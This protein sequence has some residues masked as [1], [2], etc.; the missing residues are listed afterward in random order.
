M[1]RDG[2]VGAFNPKTAAWRLLGGL[3]PIITNS[4]ATGEEGMY[5][6]L[7]EWKGEVVLVIRYTDVGEP[8]QM[9]KLDRTMMVWSKIEK[10]EDAAVFW[11]RKQAIARL[12]SL[13]FAHGA[14][15]NKVYEP[16]FTESDD[17]VR[18]C[19][20]YSLETKEYSNCTWNL[21]GLKEPL[22][23]IWFEPNLDDYE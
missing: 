15:C 21:L 10:L 5:E 16:T 8:I 23:A 22:N 17:G 14:S 11:D 13:S 9:F 6:H 20:F 2:K 1:A 12:S 3:Q 18:E 4:Y 19:V 7:V